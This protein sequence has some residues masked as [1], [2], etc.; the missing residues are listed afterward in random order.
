MPAFLV[1]FGRKNDD[2][3]DPDGKWDDTDSFLTTTV[4]AATA[5]GAERRARAQWSEYPEWHSDYNLVS[6][7]NLDDDPPF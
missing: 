3:A 6:I 7:D 1:K 5:E 4:T 2:S